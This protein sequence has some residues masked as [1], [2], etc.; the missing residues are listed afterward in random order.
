MFY[1]IP[2]G[3]F[4]KKTKNLIGNGVVIDPIIFFD[5]LEKL[6]KNKI[7][8]K[9]NLFISRKAHLIL[10]T[11]RY[12]DAASE[13]AKGKKKVGSTLKGIGPTYMDKTGRN[14]LRVGDIESK[15]FIKKFKTLT[16]KHNEILLKLYNYKAPNQL[17]DEKFG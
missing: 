10:P 15:S 1:T 2:S 5:E 13:L 14:G 11:H 6:K 9:N 8:Y 4:Q 16:K 12:L 17:E 3:I 7:L